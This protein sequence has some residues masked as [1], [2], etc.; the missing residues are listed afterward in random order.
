MVK[1]QE[2]KKHPEVK[3]LLRMGALLGTELRACA[4]QASAAPLS[5]S[6]SALHPTLGTELRQFTAPL[7]TL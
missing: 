5:W 3:Y 2:M 6:S 7:P 4:C 1:C